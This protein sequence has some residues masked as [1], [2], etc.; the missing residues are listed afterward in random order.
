MEILYFFKEDTMR[1]FLTVVLLMLRCVAGAKFPVSF[2][3]KLG[4]TKM[5]NL[6]LVFVIAFA[7]CTTAMASDI[8]FYVGSVNP[9]WYEVPNMLADVDTIIAETGSMFTDVSQFDDDQLDEFGAWVDERTDNGI[10]DIIW[11]NG[12]MPSVLY[13]FPNVDP[14]GSRAEEWLDGG[15]MIINVGDWFGY[16]SYEGGSRSAD[17][18]GAGAANILDLSSG[19]IVSADNTSLVVTPTGKEYLPSLND[20]A[21][22]YRPVVLSAVEPPWEVAA[23]F[24][25]TGGTDDPGEAQADP[26]VLYNTE[27]EGYIVIINQAAGGPGSWI[28]DRG[29]T[30]AEFIANWVNEVIGLGGGGNPLARRP[31]PEDG[32]LHEDT[33]ISL[34]W[35]A[36]YYAISHD[37]YIGD[38]FDDVNAGAESTFAGNLGTTNLVAG[39]PGFPL[40][41]GLVPGTTYYWRIDEVNEAEPNSPWKGNIWSFSIPPRTA[42]NANPA[43]GAKFIDPEADLS[44]TPGFGGKLHTVYFGES[45][46][47]VNNAAGGLPQGISTYDPGTLEP[48]KTYYWRVDEFDAANTYKGNV[49]SFTVAG[50]GGGVR[51]NYYTGMNFDSHA[52]TRIDP[53]INFAWG[54]SGPD[55]AV[56]D[57]NFSA[58]W[59]GEVEAA[60]TETYTFYTNSDDGVRLWI[61]GQQ[62]VD[63][64]TD[65]GTTENS[66]KIDLVA[67]NTYSLVMEF[68]ENGGGAVAELRWSSPS[69]PKDLI[70]QAALSLPVK[71]GQPNPSNNA[72][73][74][75]QRSTLSWSAG[76][77]AASHDVYFGTDTDAVKNAD[78]SSSEF[79]GNRP[80]GSESYDPGP[81]AWDTT[82]YWRVDEVEA[83]GTIQTGNVWSFTTANFLIIDD[84]ES[85]NDIDEGEEGSNRIYIAWEDG[86]TNPANG[87]SIVG[88]DNAPFAEQTIVHSGRQSMPFAYDNA[89]GKS[90]ATL[91]LT[92]PRDWTEN[93]VGILAIWYIGDAANAAETMYVVLNGSASVDNPDANAA[94]VEDWTE[95]RVSLSEFGIN[96]TNVNTI[97]LGFRSGTGG[98]GSVFFDDIRLHLP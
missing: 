68:Y 34:S 18:G 70:P 67:G 30:C 16:M 27:T 60:F 47:D 82:Y 58:R 37:A 25:T 9:G 83:G 65:H 63:N 50:E 79:K 62:I 13:Q 54:N 39:F 61:D 55:P 77:T 43:D 17:N 24:A 92:Y 26:V 45:F 74:V 2:P 78:T 32:A 42:Y 28:D 95:W 80:L 93:G 6:V 14:D 75:S 53:Q 23:A 71:A 88:Y 21:I 86:I 29:M 91:T 59:N 41:D 84:M 98:T 49:W 11:L 51:G 1:N 40:P 90:E 69:T 89:T 33:W 72:V 81:L 19:I 20:P 35:K 15:N 22:T 44:W 56:G 97:T 48:D 73:D 94:Q 12:C 36:G 4:G 57:D 87:G 3:L 66:G 10:M 8:A 96:L 52:L 5:K 46:D 7:F 76:E 64:W 85:Y 31:D 38:N